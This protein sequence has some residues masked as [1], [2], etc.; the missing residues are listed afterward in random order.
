MLVLGHTGITLG[1][2]ALL[3]GIL[4]RGYA[5]PTRMNRE[6]PHRDFPSEDTSKQD[7]SATG[8]VSVVT[9]FIR[10][11][12]TRVLLIGSLLPDIIDKPIGNYLFR[13]TVSNGRIV[14]HTLLF[15]ILVTIPVTCPQ[16]LYHSLS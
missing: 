12:D 6:M 11:I 4:S 9:H 16:Q 10:D 5:S 8:M 13:D 14:C 7:N 3:S 1:I 15:F 2:A